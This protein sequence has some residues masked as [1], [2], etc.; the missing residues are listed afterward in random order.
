VFFSGIAKIITFDV[1]KALTDLV[2]SDAMP[3]GKLPLYS[4]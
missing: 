1:H 3:L 4:W 2:F